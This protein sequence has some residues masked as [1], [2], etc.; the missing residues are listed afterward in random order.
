MG[1]GPWPLVAVTSFH[2][3]IP[4]KSD[5]MIIVGV[6]VMRGLGCVLPSSICL[7]EETIV[8]LAAL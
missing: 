3:V 2:G 4:F 7:A 8:T 6:M 5:Q 1:T